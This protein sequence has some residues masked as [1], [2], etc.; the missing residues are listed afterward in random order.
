VAW[1]LLPSEIEGRKAL[2]RE[3]LKV[4]GGSYTLAAQELQVSR[5]TLAKWIRDLGMEDEVWKEWPLKARQGVRKAQF[6]AARK[7]KR[8]AK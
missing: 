4:A 5:Q 2:I 1:Y 6:V 7:A 3:S 8:Q